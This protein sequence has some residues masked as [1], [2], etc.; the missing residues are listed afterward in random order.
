L[1]LGITPGR[2][3]TLLVLEG[4]D[5]LN[6]DTGENL[7]PGNGFSQKLMQAIKARRNDTSIL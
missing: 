5:C 6:R 7:M 2:I 4:D 3:E 1:V